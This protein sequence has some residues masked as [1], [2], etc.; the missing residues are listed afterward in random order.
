MKIRM[1]SLWPFSLAAMLFAS[2]PVI[3]QTSLTV[4]TVPGFPGATVPV[5]VTLRQ[6]GGS[7]AVAAQFDLAFNS[8]KIS[9]L[10]ALRG[11]QLT[12][13]VIRSRQ[14]APGVERVLIYSRITTAMGGIN[15]NLATL[16]FTVS[17]SEHTGS[18]PLTP[19]RVVLSSAAGTSLPVSSLAAGTIFIQPVNVLPNGHVQFFLATEADQ[20]YVIEA[21]TNLINWVNISTNIASGDYMNL[22]DI[23]AAKY[24]YRFYRWRIDP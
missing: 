9:P 23:D 14:I 13:H 10:T 1:N 17:S 8:G 24:P 16:P 22:V 20:R 12:N 6:R 18:G 5:P 7:S 2:S 19:D 15:V 21:T 4:G 3:A 11:D